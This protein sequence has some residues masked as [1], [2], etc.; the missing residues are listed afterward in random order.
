MLFFCFR[1]CSHLNEECLILH[2]EEISPAKRCRRESSTERNTSRK[3][4]RENERAT[5]RASERASER[6]RERERERETISPG[7][8]PVYQCHSVCPSVRFMLLSLSLS[9][10]SLSLS[11]PLSLPHPKVSAA[12]GLRPQPLP[13]LRRRRL[14]CLPAPRLTSHSGRFDRYWSI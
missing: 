11:L 3:K 14:P 5:E 12:R 6:A 10:L 7:Q 2:H 1:F 8:Y 13:A 4:Q 9:S